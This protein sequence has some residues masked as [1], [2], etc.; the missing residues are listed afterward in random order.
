MHRVATRNAQ[1]A[2][3]YR[4]VDTIIVISFSSP[5]REGMKPQEPVVR[6]LRNRVGRAVVF[7]LRVSDC[8]CVHARARVNVCI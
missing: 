6:W 8:V 4:E 5:V 1:H 7:Q 2:S 3:N